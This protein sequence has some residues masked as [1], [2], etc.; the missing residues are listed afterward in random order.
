MPINTQQDYKIPKYSPSKEDAQLILDV[1]ER[2]KDLKSHRSMLKANE[3]DTSGTTTNSDSG[4]RTKGRTIEQLFDYCDYVSL[5]HK[6]THPEMQPWMADNSHC[7]TMAKIDTALSTLIAKNPEVEIS[8]RNTKWEQKVKVLEGLYNIS[9]DKGNG[10]QQLI[11]FVTN[12]AKYGTAVAR[13]YHR[14]QKDTR[15]EV[16]EYNPDGVNKTEKVEVTLHDEAYFEVLPIRDCYFDNRAKPYDED[17]LRDWYWEMEYDYS[18]FQKLFANYPNA[19]FVQ[20]GVKDKMD[21]AEKDLPN[22]KV[23]V[24]FYENK[25]NNEFI[26]TDGLVLIHKGTLLNG[27]LSCVIGMWKMRNDF[28]IY[29]VGIAEML[30]NNQVM[31]DRIAN[32]TM[33]Q[34]VLS[35]GGAGFYGG[36]GTV[37]ASDMILEPKLKKLPDADKITFPKIP[38]PSPMTL[39]IIEFIMNQAD[40]IS[41]VTKALG[42]EQVG[43]TL[44]E[45]VLNKEAGLARLSLPLNNLQFA[46]ERH[47]RLRIDTLQ[48]IYSRPVRTDI[49]KGDFD[50][51][52]DEKLWSEYLNERQAQGGETVGMIEK[53]PLD[54]ATGALY[55][56]NYKQERLPA[57]QGIDGQMQTTPKDR[58]LEVT[59]EEIRGEFDVRIRAMSTLPISHALDQARALET[60]NIV[61]QLPYTDIHK[62]EKTLLK[63]R[64]DNPDDWML[65][66]EQIAQT[67][68]QAETGAQAVAAMGMEQEQG[69]G[70]KQTGSSN[71]G[72]PKMIQPEKLQNQSASG[73]M[74]AQFLKPLG[75]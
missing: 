68:Q 32:M 37:S 55:K 51:V 53:Y 22:K 19:K 27:Q 44:G 61:A 5:P 10:R 36:R 63:A 42:G 20:G 31:L 8:A 2:M 4:V 9:W 60:F 12:M 17:S 11:K 67:Q 66:D 54:E 43:R 15:E 25:E 57:E 41:G 1:E 74:S 75:A 30:E 49:I 6:Y 38:D 3:Y 34:I 35:I 14:Y 73:G 7:L 72:S 13:E 69:K 70:K 56:N 16:I 39:Q 58:W 46:L 65:T 18:T 47:A 23:S 64:R 33:N 59:P 29:G 21:N 50:T 48:R 40:E 52:V 62:A 45:A 71:G 26:V 24:R 28:S